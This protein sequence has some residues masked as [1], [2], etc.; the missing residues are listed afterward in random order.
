VPSSRA[1]GPRFKF[2]AWG[3][4]LSVM[5]N[6]FVAVERPAGIERLILDCAAILLT[7]LD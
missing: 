5:L 2:S 6:L 1:A 7:N 4:V 3:V